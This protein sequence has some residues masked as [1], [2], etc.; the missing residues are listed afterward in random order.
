MNGNFAEFENRKEELKQ[1]RSEINA[2]AEQENIS[3][4]SAL[5]ILME[6]Y[7]ELQG[8]LSETEIA[9]L[10]DCVPV[11]IGNICIRAIKKNTND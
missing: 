4:D 1:I 7:D 11:V 8:G 3:F 5:L 9:V 10:Y 2:F 6:D